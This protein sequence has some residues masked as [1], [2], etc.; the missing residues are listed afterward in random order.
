MSVAAD[1]YA[2]FVSVY[3]DGVDARHPHAMWMIGTF[4]P[5]ESGKY[6]E[7]VYWGES[8][9]GYQSPGSA[10]LVRLQGSV[11][12]F[13][14]G[15]EFVPQNEP[16]ED[17][18]EAQMARI[19]AGEEP[20]EKPDIT[21]TSFTFQCERCSLRSRARKETLFPIFDTLRHAGVRELSLKALAA[22]L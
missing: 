6:G 4:R 15:D 16:T 1:P 19:V 10:E 20:I 22:R 17:D 12:A 11:T 18:M 2:E 13:L 3:C 8:V 9:Q 7:G 5:D 14:A 21:R